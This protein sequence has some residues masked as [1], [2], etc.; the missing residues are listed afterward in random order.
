MHT[1]TNPRPLVAGLSHA[2]VITADLDRL[3]AFYADVF[4]AGRL[5][6][7]APPG[8]RATTI[9]LAPTVGLAVLELPG[10][11]HVDGRGPMLDRGHLDHIAFD[12]AGPRELEAV[13]QRL[14]ARG[15]SDGVVHD[16]GPMLAV[17]FVDPDGMETE[18]GW[19][20][21][22]SFADAHAPVPFTGSLVDGA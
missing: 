14:V 15:A 5:D 2:A 1:D 21:D 19:T 10:S 8:T 4:D 13:R 12:V 7:P 6:V 18:V 11:A 16:Y 22:P 17:H 3:A 20:R 9:Q